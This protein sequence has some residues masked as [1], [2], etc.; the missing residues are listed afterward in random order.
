M[1]INVTKKVYHCILSFIF[2]K[3]ERGMINNYL[4]MFFFL[5]T[6]MDL[7]ILGGHNCVIALRL[8]KCE[9]FR[10]ATF[11]D[12]WLHESNPNLTKAKMASAGFF[13]HWFQ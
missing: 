8:L 11:P 7:S 1:Y 3:K 12:N 5:F 6:D 9:L 13:L 10:L 2:I 4:R